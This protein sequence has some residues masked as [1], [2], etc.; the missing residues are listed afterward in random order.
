MKS[1]ILQKI[2]DYPTIIIH[3]HVR[4]DPDAIGSQVGLQKLLQRHFPEKE[5]LVVGQDEPTLSWLAGMDQVSNEQYQGALVIV[6]DTA[7]LERVDDQRYSLGE[8]LIKIDHHPNDEPYGDLVWVDTSASSTAEMIAQFALDNGLDLDDYTAKLLYA[9]IIGDT[10]RFLFPSTSAKTLEVASDLRKYSFDAA[11][12]AR[13]M[14]SYPYKIA[15][16]Q[17]YVYDNLETDGNG[18]AR[19]VLTRELLRQY[20]LTDAETSL[21]VNAPGKILDIQVWAVF[22]EQESGTY[23]VRLRSKFVPINQI[24]KAHDGGGH[25]LAS[26]AN[27]YS[28]AENDA[29]YQALRD[30]VTPK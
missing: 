4:P 13:Y 1:T 28:L 14:D 30:L 12:L 27:S 17:G 2:K 18:A 22:V 19:V 20:D 29:I 15:K 5:I 25:P 10:G 9:G 3:R 11:E 23:R 8:C 21:I 6:T 16:L 26:G 7:N 24:A